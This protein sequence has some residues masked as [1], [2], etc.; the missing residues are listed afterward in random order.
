MTPQEENAAILL[1]HSRIRPEFIQHDGS[2]IASL[3][4]IVERR[5]P[6]LRLELQQDDSLDLGVCCYESGES[7]WGRCDGVPC[8]EPATVFDLLTQR[9]TCA[10]HFGMVDG[11]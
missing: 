7:M 8:I 6:S 1:S 9:E 10:K 2:T 3:V 11:W 5:M 4:R